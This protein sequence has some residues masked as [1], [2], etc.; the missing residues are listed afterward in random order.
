MGRNR[1]LSFIAQFSAPRRDSRSPT[2]TSSPKTDPFH[3][4]SLPLPPK[5]HVRT[6]SLDTPSPGAPRDLASNPPSASSATTTPPSEAEHAAT[7]TSLDNSPSSSPTRRSRRSSRPL[8]MVQTYQPPVMAVTEQTLPELQ[9]IFTLL[10]SHSNKLYQEGYFLKLDDQDIRGKPN[11]DRTWTECFAQLVGT[12]LSLWDAAELDT[13]GEDGEVL[14]KFINL[15]DASIKMIE[16]LPTKSNDEQPLQ[17]ILS[18]STAGRNRYLLHFN[19]HHSLVQWTAGIRLAMYEHSTLQEAY[20]G[21]LV[22]GKGK[23]LNNINIVMERARQPVAEWVRVRFGAGVPWKRCYCVIE[24]PSEKEYQKAQKEHKKRSPY[25]RSQPVL[26]GEVRFFDT[27]KEADKKKKHQRPIASITDAYSAYA[28]YPQAK[29]LIDSSTL[30]KVEGN[31]TIH[32]DPSSS[33]EGFVFIMPETH[34]AVSGFEMLLRFLFPT[35]DTFALYGRPGRLVASV[36]DTRSLMFAMPKNRRYGYLELLDV[37]GLISTDASATWSEREWRKR[38]KEL[39]GQRMAAMEDGAGSHSRST[40]RN[41]K[42]LSYGNQNPGPRPKVGFADDG[43]SVRSSRSMSASRPG[44]RTDSAP[45]DP[46]RERAPSALAGHSRHSRHI[47]DTQLGDMPPGFGL[48]TSPPAQPVLRTGPDRVRAFAS[49]L[50]STPERVSSE[51]DSPVKGPMAGNFDGMKRMETPEPVNAPPA[52]AHSA[53]SRPQQ[54]PYPSP[55]MRKATNRLSNT[56]LS[57]LA[58]ASGLTPEALSDDRQE[59]H[60]GSESAGPGPRNTDQRGLGVQ[61]Q[62]SARAVGMNANINGSR[63]V[64]TSPTTAFSSRDAPTPPPPLRDP[65]RKRSNSPLRGPSAGPPGNPSPAFRPGP[66]GGPHGGPP[67]G[68]LPPGGRR[69]PPPGPNQP[70]L[71]PSTAGGSPPVNRKPLPVRTTSLSRDH[72]DAASP[73][74]SHSSPRTFPSPGPGQRFRPLNEFSP[75]PVPVQTRYRQNGQRS[76]EEVHDDASSTAS[77]DYASTRRSIDTQESVDRPRAGVLKVVGDGAD[78]ASR[79]ASDKEYDIPEINFGPTLNYSNPV[80]PGNKGSAKESPRPSA[81]ASGRKPPGLAATFSH[82]RQQSDDTVRRSVVWPG[83]STG[84]SS[85]DNLASLQ[86]SLQPRTSPTP[87]YAHQRV[88]STNTL[89]DYKASHSRHSS[90]DL[91][92][93]GR[94]IGQ[95]HSRHSS[96]D[97]LSSGRPASR[98]AGGVLSGGEPYKRPGSRGLLHSRNSS[99]DLLASGRPVSQGTAAALSA[100]EAS[101]YLSAREQEHVARVT[102]SPLIALAGSKGPSQTQSGLVGAIDARERERAQMRQGIGGQAV[103]QAID[104]R[105]REQNQQAQRATQA[106][107][108]QQQAQFAAQQAQ[109]RPQTPGGMSMMMGGGM[110]PSY[111]PQGQ[112]RPQTPG[113]MGM[114]MDGGG[115]SPSYGPQGQARPQTPGAMSRM[116]D[117]APSGYAPSMAGMNPRS[118]NPGPNMMSPP[119]GRFA[120]GPPQPRPQMMSPHAGSYGGGV[121][122]PGS[123][124]P[125]W[126]MGNMPPRQGPPQGPVMPSPSMGMGMGFGMQ[127]GGGHPQSPAYQ[128]PPPQGQYAPPGTPGGPRPGTPGRMQQYHG[129]AF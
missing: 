110:P 84:S 15:T 13:A 114:M 20:T 21:A 48:D 32:T 63:E 79:S 76:A 124:G 90:A 62:T 65:S 83:P 40:S 97:M 33:T 12:V 31:I 96:V 38:L 18:I 67:Y 10:N 68:G 122:A 69:T 23:A 30:L 59:L 121:G 17:N 43:G 93:S 50:A 77:P 9:P 57:Q 25:D 112:A 92:S 86:Q 8:S 55:E 91:L 127:Q 108:A 53:G 24:P 58:R 72:H 123:P 7:P 101:S 42:R 99:A 119:G 100:G 117:G 14:P 73:V 49:D 94:P 51:D 95:S 81:P 29:E 80:L 19:S 85:T 116:M 47:S 113:A 16:S 41:S 125:R 66:H 2:P 118:M 105:H 70:Q 34:P 37:S 46:N 71:F 45:P 128:L 88:P 64:L 56:T 27:K 54:K 89:G 104:Q 11:P 61:P 126:N 111:G 107:Y 75:P 98:G 103:A 129:Q 36:L 52:F 102:G 39:T 74:S 22:A 44:M 28:I 109:V 115:F 106:A 78:G 60:F 35:W 120:Q 26:K 82:A 87:Q 5:P 3:R 6:D 1:V 4:A